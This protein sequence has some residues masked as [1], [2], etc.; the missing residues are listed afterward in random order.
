MRNCRKERCKGIL[1]SLFSDLLLLGLDLGFTGGAA[2]TAIPLCVGVGDSMDKRNNFHRK[3]APYGDG[4]TCVSGELTIALDIPPFLVFSLCQ[5]W[6]FMGRLIA[7]RTSF[8]LKA[9]GAKNYKLVG[10]VLQRG[11]FFSLVMTFPIGA[12]WLFTEKGLLLL[13]QVRRRNIKRLSGFAYF[14]FV[15]L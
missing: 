14:G 1:P 10:I 6:Y 15:T 3:R 12:L 5:R 4:S 2:W 7:N 9:Y 8:F 13:G 11:L